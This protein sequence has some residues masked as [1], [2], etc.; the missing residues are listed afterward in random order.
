MA[1]TGIALL[2]FRHACSYTAVIEPMAEGT[3]GRTVRH[4]LRV[5]LTAHLLCAGVR[6][7]REASQAELNHSIRKTDATRLSVDRRFVTDDAHLAFFVGEVLR[8]AFDA[9]GMA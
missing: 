5:H 9:R 8:V 4:L 7:V 1:M 2:M 3:P 6:T